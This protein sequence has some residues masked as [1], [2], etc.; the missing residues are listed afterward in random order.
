M[1]QPWICEH[2]G[3]TPGKSSPRTRPLEVGLSGVSNSGDYDEL[4]PVTALFADVVGSTSLGEQLPPDEV[5]VLIGECVTRMTQAVES[6][7][8]VVRSYM[9]DGIAA[10]FGIDGAMEDDPIRAGLAGLRILEVISEYAREIEAAWD[11]PSVAVRLGI[12]S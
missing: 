2:C 10:F 1:A 11:I 12:N 8:G 3:A 5:K 7:G 6:Y 9:G 4:R